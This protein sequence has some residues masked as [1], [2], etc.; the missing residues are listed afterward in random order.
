MPRSKEAVYEAAS[1][2]HAAYK[3]WLAACQSGLLEVSVE[4][5]GRVWRCVM[6]CLMS[7]HPS[8]SP[9]VIREWSH[10]LQDMHVYQTTTFLAVPPSVASDDT[11]TS[12]TTSSNDIDSRK[13]PGMPDLRPPSTADVVYTVETDPFPALSAPYIA[14]VIMEKYVVLGGTLL[15]GLTG[16]VW[17][18]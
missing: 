12:S 7:M 9:V 14:A 15:F 18:L 6:W 1:T 3:Q 11:T 13:D 8:L 5:V 17:C 16:Q 2:S 10:I 4:D